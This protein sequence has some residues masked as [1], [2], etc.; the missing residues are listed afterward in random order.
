MGLEVVSAF[1]P[2]G[3][4]EALATRADK[5]VYFDEKFLSDI[6]IGN[7]SSASSNSDEPQPKSY[8]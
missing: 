7:Q 2:R 6:F 4:S 5:V 3:L 1:F 8:E